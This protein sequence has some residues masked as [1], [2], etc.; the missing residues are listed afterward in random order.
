[1]SRSLSWISMTGVAMTASNVLCGVVA[2]YGHPLTNGGPAWVTWSYLTIGIMSCIVSFCLAE[3][4]AAYPTTA[5]VHHWV[6]QLA[7]SRQKPFL[8]WITGWLTLVGTVASASSVA[9]Y[10][11][12][13]LGQVLYSIYKIALTPGMLVMFHLG[14]VL[15]WQAFNLFPVKGL[16]YISTLGGLYIFGVAVT[17]TV[18]MLSHSLVDATLVHVP[19]TVFLNYSGNSNAVYAS[20]S[21]ALMASFIFC[22][23]DS[24]IRMSEETQRPERIVPKL[25][26]G[27]NMIGLI[28][29]LPLVIVLNYG[30]LQPMKGLLDEA[31][32]AV[33]VILA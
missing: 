12:S 9:F 26:I 31:A 3:L 18:V 16:G 15:F 17:T 24:V 10:F 22:P 13:V 8:T 28:L 27:S 11:S 30:I 32:P 23:Q 6:Y 33:R 2:L 29:G 14:A 21:S 4:A 20:L 1:M 19:F 7:S 5:G 25:I